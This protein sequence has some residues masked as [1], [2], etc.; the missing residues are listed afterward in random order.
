MELGFIG[1]GRMGGNMVAR[2]LSGQSVSVVVHDRAEAPMAA[3]VSRGARAAGSPAQLVSML[4]GSPRVV[5]LMLP[6]GEVTEVIYREVR[7]QLGEGDI[8]IDGANS[9]HRDTSRRAVECAARGIRLLGVG[10]SGGIV[11]ADSGYPMM[12]GGDPSAYEHC[13]PVFA[14]LGLD[15]GYA[16]VGSDPSA[17]HYVKMVHNAIEYGMMQAIAEGFDLLQNGSVEGLDLPGIAGIWNH[18]TIVSS[19]LM[20]MTANALAR[21]A[22]L[23]GL[24]PF[25]ADSGEGRWA[26]IE[27]MEHGVPFVANTY[28]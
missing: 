4:S 9:N 17:G 5:W 24:A 13:L 28:A 10:V 16:L 23:S 15:K 14:G 26:A 22:D 6:A 21:D 7:E 18:G 2:L 12:I 20:Q 3:L 11:A 27:A 25:V 8:L 19:F 1:L